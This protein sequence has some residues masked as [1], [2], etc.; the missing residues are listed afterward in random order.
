MLDSAMRL[1]RK[2]RRAPLVYRRETLSRNGLP[3]RGL[4]LRQIHDARVYTQA[5]F[6]PAPLPRA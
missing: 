4:R 2:T 6:T 5:R 1:R 3:C